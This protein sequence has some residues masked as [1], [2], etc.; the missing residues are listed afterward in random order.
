MKLF[1]KLVTTAA[2]AA[3]AVGGGATAASA[4]SISGGAYTSATSSTVKLTLA[5]SYTY[6]CSSTSF[7]GVATGAD[8]MTMTPAF[9]GC[10]YYGFPWVITQSG[11]WKI[12]VTGGSAP[13]FTGEL[14]IPA[15]VTTTWT[16]PITGCTFVIS[17]PQ[18]LRHGVG[19]N[20]AVI[21][22]MGTGAELSFHLNGIAFTATSCPYSSGTNGVLDSGGGISLPGI[23][24]S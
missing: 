10:S 23:T 7:S 16:L 2:M 11:A 12:K 15:G 6:A 1:S 18:T 20:A 13:N 19:G 9:G 21:R 14:E 4:Y 24:V 3:L 17:G 5:G 8:T 22:N